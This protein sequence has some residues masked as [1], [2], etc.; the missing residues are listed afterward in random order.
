M[1]I[2]FS[3]PNPQ[4]WNMLLAQLPGAHILQTWEWACLKQ[5][6]GWTA[7][8]TLWQ[9]EQGRPV[10]AAMVLTRSLP[11]FWRLTGLRV[12][13]VPKGPVCDWNK[14]EIYLQVLNDLAVFARKE[15][16]IFLKMDAD[17]SQG[18]GIPGSDLDVEN[19]AGQQVLEALTRLGWRL[20]QEQVQFR[21]TVVIDLSPGAEAIL[22]GMKQKTR[23]NIRLASRKGISVRHAGE[24]DFPALYRLYAETSVRD[25]FV[26]RER[27]YYLELWSRF[28]QAGMLTP[29]A[30][31]FDDKIIAGLMLFH[32]AGHAWYIHG[33]S[34]DEQREKMP[35]YLLQWI[36]IQTAAN[37]G[38]KTY[39]L[40]GAPDSFDESDEMWG[41]FRFKEGLGGEVVRHIG[42]W[43]FPV[44]PKLYQLYTQILPRILES[45]RRAGRARTQ[46][47]I[48]PPVA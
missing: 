42:A 30:A 38:C 24:E 26:I 36:A 44:R 22:A 7:Q 3:S 28:L 23:Y 11:N 45:M 12:M 18:T 35:N 32:F 31:V 8:P 47:S 19:P 16:A 1:T 9:D 39:D 25:G 41:V 33:M 37:L 4:N 29:L 40:W 17:I 20:S 6:Y 14:P 48:R 13:Y 46:S 15:K 27:D 43:D 2:S 21:N 5:A 34:A 10:A